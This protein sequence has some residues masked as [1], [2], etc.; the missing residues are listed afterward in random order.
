MCT[1]PPHCATQ[2]GTMFPFSFSLSLFPL[3][4]TAGDKEELLDLPPTTPQESS[5][6]GTPQMS[7]RQRLSD[8]IH[9]L[10]KELE[11]EQQQ[12][13]DMG[14]EEQ[15]GYRNA[16]E[17]GEG[18]GSAGYST[19]EHFNQHEY[20]DDDYEDQVQHKRQHHRHSH[21]HSRLKPNRIV[22]QEDSNRFATLAADR[23]MGFRIA[24]PRNSLSDDDEAD[25]D[26]VADEDEDEDD[27]YFDENYDDCDVDESTTLRKPSSSSS[28]G[29]HHHHHQVKKIVNR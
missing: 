5:T 7:R 4:L 9:E 21:S 19:S 12:H 11:G 3:R 28:S 25:D 18:K 15:G 22:F 23:A 26:S 14:A 13:H 29:H 8:R 10:N 24:P 1:P 2:N 6:S 27:F 16:Y 17:D 20:H